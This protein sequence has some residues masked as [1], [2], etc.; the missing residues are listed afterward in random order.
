MRVAFCSHCGQKL[1]E[2][3]NFCT[4]C[5]FRTRHGAEA[6]VTVPM[7]DW[8]ETFSKIGLEI[9]KA[10]Q[11]AGKEIEKAVK[12]VREDWADSRGKQSVVC[13]DCGAKNSAS[14]VFCTGCGKKL[15][16]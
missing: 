8:R 16:D 12:T 15:K 13:K 14:A 1:P 5:G 4:A 3:A 10:F 11:T 2:D 9:E 7:E 6:G